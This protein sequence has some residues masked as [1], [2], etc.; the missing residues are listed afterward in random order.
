MNG[1]RGLCLGD[2]MGSKRIV[3]IDYLKITAML[4]VVMSHS[5][6]E[7]L[8]DHVLSLQW[9]ISNV[10]IGLVSP[11][12]GIFYMVSGALILSSRHTND[13]KYLWTHRLVKIVVPF[14]IWSA[15]TVGVLMQVAGQFKV[16]TWFNKLLLIYHQFPIIPFWFLYPLIGFYLIS[17]MIKA[18]VDNA[19]NKLIDYILAVWFVTN[20]LFPFLVEVLPHKYGIY[21]TYIPNSNMIFLGQTFGYFLLGYRLSKIQVKANTFWED[22]AATILLLAIT[23]VVNIENVA[24]HWKFPVIGYTSIV[25]VILAM[26]IF[27]MVRKF[28]MKH[29]I[30]RITRHYVAEIS[31]LTYGVYLTHGLV[32]Q[33][34]EQIFKITNAF[35]VFLITTAICLL[36]GFIISKIPKVRFFLLG[37]D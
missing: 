19:S 25:A 22:F 21:F 31:T 36:F 17:P 16:G 15:I 33:L 2:F 28:S 4:G 9:H 37:M 14:I 30:N 26:E 5:L 1:L 12:V 7:T 29:P 6:A 3:Y 20:I 13:I 34:T 35:L 11:A 32:I 24:F 18:F 10:L 8:N 23:I 27:L